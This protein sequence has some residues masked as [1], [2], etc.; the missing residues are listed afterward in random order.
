MCTCGKKKGSSAPHDLSSSELSWGWEAVEVV[1]NVRQ[2]S[3]ARNGD[4]AMSC[5]M[6]QSGLLR[7]EVEWRWSATHT[8]AKSE[9]VRECLVV[10]WKLKYPEKSKVWHDIG[11]Q[12]QQWNALAQLWTFC[13]TI[14]QWKITIFTQIGEPFLVLKQ[15]CIL[16]IEAGLGWLI[17]MPCRGN[18]Q[19][20]KIMQMLH[21]FI[22]EH[23]WH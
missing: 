15:F 17:K 19:V 2:D 8:H 18:S 13:T 20:V 21:L 10:M 7:R 23:H 5:S 11:Y 22:L 6:V 4:G 14:L 16:K 1:M 9:E 3:C 12:W